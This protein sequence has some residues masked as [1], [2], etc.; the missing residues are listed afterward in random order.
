MTTYYIDPTAKVNGSGTFASPFK[1]WSNVTWAAGNTYLQ[2]AGTVERGNRVLV[3]AGGTSLANRVIVGSYDPL[4]GLRTTGGVGRAILDGTGTAQ[5]IRVNELVNFVWIDNFEV[6]GTDGVGGS[7][8]KAVYLGNGTASTMSNDIEVSNCYIH[9]VKCDLFPA[10]DNDGIQA[11]GDRITIRNCIVKNIPTDGIWLQGSNYR[12]V[13]NVIANVSTNDLKGDCIQTNGDASIRNDNGYIARN[14]LDH[15]SRNA[16]QVIIVGGIGFSANAVIEDNYCVMADYDNV[17]STSA[18]FVEAANS[19]VRRNY[20]Q[21]GYFGICASASGA[22]MFAH[23]NLCYK[24]Q[25]GI[26]IGTATTGIRVIGNTIIGAVLQGVEVGLDLTAVVKSNLLLNC[27]TGVRMHGS[28]AE[29]YNAFFG[30]GTDR[31]LAGGTA[32]W[33]THDVFSDPL[34]NAYYR[35]TASSPLIAA[36][37][38]LD[39][40]PLLDAAGMQFNRVPTIGAFEYIRPRAGRRG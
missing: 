9:D 8:A 31:S 27:V 25:R 38:P 24:N 16:K 13:D 14:I 21:G 26:G 40:Y 39:T 6:Y 22:N 29:D 19:I 17:T 5:T 15:S 33:G 37:A 3:M 23:S 4:T 34:L 10:A 32:N 1:S 18:I 12:I 20:V 28:A 36:G 30:N 11:F 2:K 35:P 7:S